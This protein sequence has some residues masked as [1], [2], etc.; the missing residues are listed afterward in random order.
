MSIQLESN[1]SKEMT[2]WQECFVCENFTKKGNKI[3]QCSVEQ[4]D[5]VSMIQLN[6]TSDVEDIQ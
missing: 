6:Y 2:M 4:S 3:N 1:Q 5:L